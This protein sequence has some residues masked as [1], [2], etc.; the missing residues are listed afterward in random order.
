M[1]PR[2]KQRKMKDKRSNGGAP[3]LYLYPTVPHICKSDLQ[4]WSDAVSKRKVNDKRNAT[5]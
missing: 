2:L 4:M 3:V 5:K 1:E